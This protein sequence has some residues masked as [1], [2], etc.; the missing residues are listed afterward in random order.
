MATEN[1][2]LVGV[3]RQ[4]AQNQGTYDAYSW[5][6]MDLFGMPDAPGLYPQMRYRTVQIKKSLD[7]RRNFLASIKV[8]FAG[9][10]A[11]QL[12]SWWET[13][14]SANQ[15][16][17]FRFT[18]SSF[19]ANQLD[20]ISTYGFSLQEKRWEM[21]PDLGP[22]LYVWQIDP[23]TIYE[24]DQPDGRI[25]KP[26][27]IRFWNT[28]A[29]TQ[30]YLSAE[31]FYLESNPIFPGNFWGL[32]DLYPLI[33]DYLALDAEY[34]L[35]LEARMIEKGIIIAQ[36]NT[37]GTT[38]ASYRNMTTALQGV[39]RGQSPAIIM[40]KGW[41]PLSVLQYNNGTDAVTQFN[42]A[43]DKFDERIKLYFDSTLATLGLSTSGS[44]ALGETFKIADQQKFEAFLENYFEDFLASE[45][46]LDICRVLEIPAEEVQLATPGIQSSSD[47]FDPAAVLT[48]MKDTGVTF[49]SLGE[50]NQ[51][52]L[53]GSLG[54]DFDVYKAA[55]APAPTPEGDIITPTTLSED[56]P[57]VLP[58][59][60][61]QV[62]AEALLER[63]KRPSAEKGL[64]MRELDLAKRIASGD[65]LS[66]LDINQLKG[67]FSKNDPDLYPD[68]HI[69]AYEFDCLG[70][71]DMRAAL[72]P[73]PSEESESVMK[74]LEDIDLKPTEQ[75][76]REAQ[77]GLDLRRQFGRGGTA[78][79]VARARDIANGKNL[80]PETVSRMVSFFSR[81]EKS[82]KEG[83]GFKHGDEGYP[84]AGKIAWLLWGGE[85]G[86]DW[87]KRKQDEVRRVR[88]EK[89]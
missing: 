14:Q 56:L 6:T 68:N 38:E 74:T 10:H 42:T 12:N 3:R 31:Q 19:M 28:K 36:E 81:H 60:A 29:A 61:S 70:G 39:L 23:V 9:K 53:F 54:L 85:G 73:G 77:K 16:K 86:Y 22:L 45:F 21:D 59:V 35:Y 40:D 32:S 2:S 49:E 33:Q 52:I 83:K 24:F 15:S 30:L 13:F 8:E 65:E 63:S 43:R 89:V 72:N 50:E 88:G 62:A 25:T 75:M 64:S 27:Q 44:R 37:E 46:M 51:R 79:G 17:G 34:K 5:S 82:V 20:N 84:S 67:W 58:S 76:Q 11:R 57:F 26:A 87:A 41:A 66:K 7:D 80:S 18:L 48:F 1:N 4:Y 78:V 55:N 71:E 69:M 47:K